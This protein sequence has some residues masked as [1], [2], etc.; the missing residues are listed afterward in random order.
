MNSPVGFIFNRDFDETEAARL[1]RG[2]VANECHAVNGDSSLGEP[3]LK[4]RFGCL[5]RE[6]S[7]KQFLHVNAFQG[8]DSK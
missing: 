3:I 5:I 6:I 1:P 4:L 8:I 7:N 2:A